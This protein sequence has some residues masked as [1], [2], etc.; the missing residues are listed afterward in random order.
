MGDPIRV[1]R[2]DDDAAVLD[3]VASFLDRD[4][5]D[6]VT[7][8]TTRDALDRLDGS[9]D[10]VVSD[11]D[12]PE[13]DGLEFLGAV[14]DEH[15][16]LPFVLFVGEDS[17]ATAGEAISAGVTDCLR[18]D[19]DA[20]QH[21]VLA[22]RIE[23]AVARRRAEREMDRATSRYRRLVEGTIVG[24]Y[25]VR[26]DRIEYANPKLAG[27]FGYDRDELVGRSP[28]AIVAESDRQRVADR[29]EAR[30][31]GEIDELHYT[32]TGVRRDETH[33]DIEAHGGR[34]DLDDG[35]AV[36]G[37]LR[38]V[39]DRRRHEYALRALHDATDDL[40]RAHA[41]ETVVERAAT[42]AE[43]V[44]GFPIAV[45]RLYDAD[46]DTLEPV[47]VTD[48]AG[49]TL[50]ER[51]VYARDEGLPWRAFDAGEPVVADGNLSNYATSDLP[52]RSALYVPI[53]D[54]GTLSI[55]SPDGVVE[56]SDVRLAQVLAASVATALDRVAKETEL[57]RQNERL[58]EFASVVSHDLRNPLGL[59]RG[60][61]ELARAEQPSEHH[62]DIAWALSRMDSLID[63]L[64]ALARQGAVVDETVPVSLTSIAESAWLEVDDGTAELVL[65]DL[66][67]IEADPDRLQRLLGNLF[68]NAMEHGSTY[69]PSPAQEDAIEH[70]STS[71]R[72]AAGDADP[73]VTVRVER[74]A[75]GG[76]AVADDGPG[77]PADDRDR[78]F[79]SGYT[80]GEGTGLGLAI[81]RTIAGAHGW[82]ISITE[83]DAGGARFEIHT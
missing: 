29:I 70:G 74:L 68:R 63:D 67:E 38:E 31:C 39:G 2:V 16:D 57:E 78:V 60:R 24:I 3:S 18:K 17:E 5:F 72:P 10:C 69:P 13:R 28:L 40:V 11:H 66:G 46:D 52:L 75:D 59:A 53:D 64:L 8:S 36:M 73:A 23:N 79:E 44:L 21:V 61:L 6:V 83:S 33:V 14:R 43:D 35:A 55:G 81:V 47:A 30:E 65:D 45:V 19:T 34:I 77:I 12:L 41:A 25:V 9:I 26:N 80:T 71:S 1:L 37:V 42:A 56:D 62:D 32:F 4:G 27:I 20:D 82:T 7:E 50:G 48:A 15:P 22:N 54:H 51:P 76:F 49:E 58:E